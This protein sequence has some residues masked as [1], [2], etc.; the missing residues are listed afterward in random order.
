MR[1][2][3]LFEAS[4]ALMLILLAFTLCLA[5]LS[6]GGASE[7]WAISGPV[8]HT[9]FWVYDNVYAPGN[10][11]LYTVDGSYI[12]AIG[13]DGRV[14]WSLAIPDKYSINGKNEMWTGMAAASDGED[15]YIIVGPGN[16]PGKGEL[17]A[18]APNGTARWIAPLTFNL[19][20]YLNTE[21]GVHVKDGRIYLHHSRNQIILDANSSILL[22]IYGVYEPAT[23]D[24]AG[25]MYVYSQDNGS[26]ESYDRDGAMRWS[27]RAAEYN[28]SVLTRV[29][30]EQPCFR[31]G[32][33]YVWLNNGV[34]A[35]DRYGDK[36]WVKEYPDEYTYVDFYTPFDSRD[37]LY[38]RHFNTGEDRSG[39]FDGS[40]ISMVRP[41]G[42][43]VP[44]ARHY[45]SYISN[46]KGL[47]DGVYYRA[48]RVL[49]AGVN[50]TLNADYYKD[51]GTVEFIL[52]QAGDEWKN[53]RDVGQL[54][55]YAIRAVDLR[56]DGES[57]NTTLPLFPHKIILNA[58]NIGLMMPPY[59]DLSYAAK[60]NRATPE[61]WYKNNRVPNGTAAIG[62]WTDLELMPGKNVT[63]VSL[64][65][66]NYEVPT[67]Y[68]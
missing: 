25:N 64:W 59:L 9:G 40:Y 18:I 60:E 16:Q 52:T 29:H 30:V 14:K 63:Y 44:G 49:P 31:N 21:P 22:N 61:E 57:W 54:D 66:L 38:L 5:V 56:T 28:A 43:E 50:D 10:G 24:D 17:L 36:L 8:A 62:S 26:I 55:T 19:A 58:S 51:P 6:G 45:L 53:D 37:N 27:R 68:G 47:S 12:Y 35:L 4:L 46:V 42:T 13:E 3:A 20:Q 39:D 67:F 11:V 15:F 34:M 33:L 23:I 41:D 1:K 7:K 65:T 48:E 2:S 32:T